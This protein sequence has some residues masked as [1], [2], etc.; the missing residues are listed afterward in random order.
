M[1][2]HTHTHTNVGTCRTIRSTGTQQLDLR[3]YTCTFIPLVHKRTHVLT[4]HDHLTYTCKSPVDCTGKFHVRYRKFIN[5]QIR[6]VTRSYTPDLAF[7]SEKGSKTATTVTVHAL[8]AGG[9][10]PRPNHAHYTNHQSLPYVALSSMVM[11][12]LFCVTMTQSLISF[13]AVETFPNTNCCRM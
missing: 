3:A 13:F 9:H 6:N 4:S 12:C 8:C 10:K 2:T 11:Q 5:E 7:L 1:H